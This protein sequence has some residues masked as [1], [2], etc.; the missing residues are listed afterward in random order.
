MK[1]RNLSTP[2]PVAL[3]FSVILLI[4]SVVG[5]NKKDGPGIS[6]RQSNLKNIYITSLT[7]SS[8]G[9]FASADDPGIIYKSTDDGNNWTAVN[10]GLPAGSTA[11]CLA[12]NGS[13]IFA[14]VNEKVYV[15][16]NSG[17]TW[18]SVSPG[19]PANGRVSSLA[20]SGNTILVC[21]GASVFLSTNSG[22]SWTPVNSGIPPNTIVQCLAINGTTFYAGAN[23]Q[24]GGSVFIS[25]DSGSSWTSVSTG[26]TVGA[27]VRG[28]GV[29]GD[30][31]IAAASDGVYL[32]TNKGA[33]WSAVP[34]LFQR[35]VFTSISV[36]GNNIFAGTDG[37]TADVYRSI[38]N[39]N[40]WATYSSGLTK[41]SVQC[42][43]LR[44]NYIFAGTY[45]SGIF[46]GLF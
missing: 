41:Q 29:S 3:L 40:N 18:T 37:G 6:W 5:C 19:L 28:L 10:S 21:T 1:K 34:N 4:G 20:V 22:G 11:Y 14:G 33:T 9:I 45:K 42:L 46:I 7:T 23:G 36:T 44:D 16:T 24:S 26:M 32:S 27:S 17:S 43:A 25:N 15:S 12:V 31:I 39:G 13:T 38:D 8:E 2:K 30:N 35:G